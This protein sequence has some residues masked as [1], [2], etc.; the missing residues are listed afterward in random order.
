MRLH[1]TVHYTFRVAKIKRL[2]NLEDVEANIKVT[3]GFVQS[4]EVDIT[5]VYELHNQSGCL[6]HWVT[7]HVKEIN[8]VN[9]V[10]EGLQNFDLSSDLSLFYCKE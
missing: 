2:Q 1:V 4:A 6:C 5:S 8:Y 9:S 7:D 3:K 10:L